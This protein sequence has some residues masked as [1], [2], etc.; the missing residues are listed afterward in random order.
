MYIIVIFY[1]IVGFIL[2][3]HIFKNLKEY[4]WTIFSYFSSY[5][6]VFYITIPIISITT[7]NTD[8]ES[9]NNFVYNIPEQDSFPILF[10]V[11][12]IISL[13]I[14]SFLFGYTRKVHFTVTKVIPKKIGNI[15]MPLSVICFIS[16]IS[17]ASLYF[18]IKGFGSIQNAVFNAN[19]VRSGYYKE[20][21]ENSSHTF[22]FRFT[23]LSLIPI[24]YFFYQKKKEKI[25]YILFITSIILI[26]F[27]YLFLSSGRQSIIDFVLIFVFASLIRNKS[28]INK[29]LIFFGA[30]AVILLPLLEVFFK[31]KAIGDTSI[32][33]NFSEVFIN[34]FGFPYYS[35]I[36][37]IEGD[38]SFY[39]FSDFVTN[40]FGKILPSSLG[41]DWPRTNYLNSEYMLGRE[42]K[43]IPPGI[44]GQGYYSL[45]FIGVFVISFVTGYLFKVIDTF[46][47]DL[48][49]IDNG[50]IFFYAYFIT[51]SLDWVRTGLPANYF[52]D[53]VLLSTWLFL[54]VSYKYEI[55]TYKSLA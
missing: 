30:V 12:F 25:S 39:Y 4:G 5:L 21:S 31:S 46:I 36:H 32:E 42:V 34:E 3:R 43:S 10:I 22:F 51:S 53:T 18:Y 48:V 6:F 17:V 47:R 44:F 50:F 55:K 52:Y 29:K 27:L 23:F 41:P 19:F 15:S 28:V 14:L 45:G 26:T 24:I 13:G 33:F 54:W 38:H 49:N 9:I 8:P 7:F 11:F 35:L 37:S 2:G 20:I 16:F 1:L 40:L